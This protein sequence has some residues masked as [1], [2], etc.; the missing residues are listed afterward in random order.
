[1]I[2]Y[3]PFL[4][5]T[6]WLDSKPLIPRP[7]TEFWVDKAITSLKQK[8]VQKPGWSPKI[9]DLCAGSGCIGVAVA[10]ALTNAH[11][12]FAEIDPRHTPTIQK[13]CTH[14]AIA[15]YTLI[16]SNLFQNVSGQ[17]DIILSNPPYID[18]LLNRTEPS[19][20]NYEPH[21]A[22]YGGHHGLE[23]ITRIIT[24]APKCLTPGGQLWLEHEPEQVHKIETL[25]R[26][27]GFQECT[28][29]SDQYGVDRYSVLSMAY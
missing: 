17:F 24:E 11:V 7:E 15:H 19:V 29:H 20:T 25:A 10:H 23:L 8:T 9:L 6:I 3:I 13:N 4:T 16:E 28:T 5:T 22:L 1:V 26:R 18:P 14:N 21:Q 27:N 2:G 12:T